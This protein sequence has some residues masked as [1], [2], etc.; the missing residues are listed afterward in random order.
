[1]ASISA[2]GL[3]SGLDLNSLVSQLVAAERAPAENRLNRETGIINAQISALGALTSTAKGLQTS[4]SNLAS[5]VSFGARTATS[6]S[7]SFSASATSS[8]QTGSYQIRVESIATSHRLASN[9]VASADDP[10]GS[11]ELS[12][13]LGSD[14]FV[15]IFD[16][17]ASITEIRDAINQAEGNPG[18]RA[19][20]LNGADGARL[21]L[22]SDASGAQNNIQ[23]TASGGD[24]G[25]TV[26]V[27]ENGGTQNLTQVQEAKDAEVY[28]DGFLVNSAGNQIA[29]AIEGV[30]INL[31]SADPGVNHTLTIANNASP[32]VSA[33]ESFVSSYNAF[34][35]TAATV[36]RYNP[37]NN[38]AASLVGDAS[39]RS[40]GNRLRS[41][42]GG[43][44]SNG[45]GPSLLS[46]LGI[47]TNT[48]G[49]LSINKSELQQ[50]VA[51]N[52]NGVKSLFT[53]LSGGEGLADQLNTILESYV[54][55]QGV[56]T[57]RN[58]S[59]KD[60]LE[61][62]SDQRLVLDRR[63]SAIQARYQAQFTA[64]DTLLSQLQST[65]NYLTQQLSNLPNY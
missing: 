20:I 1:M 36:T 44:I 35:A 56:F 5:G 8:A 30:T 65:G 6:S 54:G 42:V 60:R 10:L 22:S 33:I 34:V 29:D 16:P 45:D 64:L 21:V 12:L 15:L 14:T 31:S 58:Q 9:A 7:E 63:I 59:A 47:K 39:V 24:G 26:L 49:T 25:L 41:L 50:A 28:V 43:E 62:I 46:Q 4:L 13:S 2:S 57:S 32:T 38:T 48:D 19:T 3:G 40:L 27:Y 61:D 55:S 52:P 53:G 18:I 11:G 17:A 23:V 37:D 51:D